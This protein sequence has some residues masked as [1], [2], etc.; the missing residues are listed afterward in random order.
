MQEDH[1]AKPPGTGF[2]VLLVEDYEP[3]VL[4]TTSFLEEL[5]HRCEVART[6]REALKKFSAAPHD[7]IFMD[8]Q[9]PDIDGLEVTR[10]IR[11]L[12]KEPNAP[13]TPIV[14]LSARA[15]E[16]D[17]LLCMKAGMNACLSKPFQ[18]DQLEEIMRKFVAVRP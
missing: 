3:N 11:V 13:S 15:N 17:R 4:V 12:E 7:I 2:F 10:K 9:L 1:E 6:G 14:A 18:R 8:L 16:E 5:G